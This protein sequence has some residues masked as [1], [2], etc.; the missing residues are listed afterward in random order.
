MANTIDVA[1]DIGAYKIDFETQLEK[2]L[3]KPA[4][5]KDVCNVR[6]TDANTMA[7][8]YMATEFVAQTGTRGTAYGF[9]DFTLTTEQLNIRTYKTVPVFVDRADAAQCSYIDFMDIAFR[10]GKLLND[11]VETAVL[12]DHA[13]W[14]NVGDSGGTI[15]SGVTTPITVS[16]TNIDNIVRGVRR[17]IGL[18]NGGELAETNGLFFVWSYTHFEFLEEY[19][20]NNGFQLADKALKDG[21]AP[22]YYFL[23]A[24]HY[25]SN[26]T[27][28]GHVMAGVRKLHQVGI[29]NTTYG[30]LVMTDDPLNQS[31]KGLITRIDFGILTPTG[32]VTLILDVNVAN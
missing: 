30:K 22:G 5:Y 4:V 13:A 29:C 24:Y 28:T 15:T 17:I 26:S 12:A 32:Y 7:F 27:A 10:H 6:F 9:S 11:Q 8:T 25:V 18:A 3:N 21:V 2:R 1:S 16:A 31:G 20:Q 23:G 14:T 19:A